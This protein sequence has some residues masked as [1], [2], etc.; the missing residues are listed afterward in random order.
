MMMA[1]NLV[2]FA[3]GVDG[4][5]SIIHGIFKDYSGTSPNSPICDEANRLQV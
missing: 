1:A 5:K 4:L 3:V 2:G